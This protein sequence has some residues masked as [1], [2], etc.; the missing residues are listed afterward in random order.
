MVSSTDLGLG[1]FF[2]SLN[3]MLA[4]EYMKTLN[5]NIGHTEETDLLIIV[6]FT[7]KTEI[8]GKTHKR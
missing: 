8:C 6:C 3:N 5:G 7:S 1:V 2:C 4:C